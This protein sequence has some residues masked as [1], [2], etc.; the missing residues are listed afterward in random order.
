MTNKDLYWIELDSGELWTAE[1]VSD[2]VSGLVPGYRDI[3]PSEREA[4]R[5][6]YAT[7]VSKAVQQQLLANAVTAGVVDLAT[8][9]DREL[10]RMLGFG[11]PDERAPWL[12]IVPLITLG[13]SDA[14]WRPPPGNVVVFDARDDGKFILSLA[15]IG[16]IRS[17]G[18]LSGPALVPHPLGL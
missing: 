18:L 7:T 14:G 4:A 17:L 11:N 2:F 3:D 12:G 13:G 16:E 8:I 15:A 6:A 1:L 5:R 10:D 9:P